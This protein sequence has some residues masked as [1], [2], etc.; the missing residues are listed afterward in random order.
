MSGMEPRREANCDDKASV[1]G[2]ED[3]LA[4]IFAQARSQSLISDISGSRGVRCE[5]PGP[6]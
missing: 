5:E 4:I 3:R 1:A 2:A 6:S